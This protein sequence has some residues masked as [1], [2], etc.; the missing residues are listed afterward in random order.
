LLVAHRQLLSLA[1]GARAVLT[2]LIVGPGS[3]KRLR[4]KTDFDCSL[5]GPLAAQTAGGR[6]SMLDARSHRPI[7]VCFGCGGSFGRSTVDCQ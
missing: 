5:A 4:K 1:Y 6:E 7:L 3:T 2:P